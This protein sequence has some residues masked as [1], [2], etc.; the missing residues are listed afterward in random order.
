MPSVLTA[1][2]LLLLCTVFVKGILALLPERSEKS[3][4]RMDLLTEAVK[5][6]QAPA[7]SEPA[8]SQ[9]A[10]IWELIRRSEI[11]DAMQAAQEAAAAKAAAKAKSESQAATARPVVSVTLDPAIAT[12]PH[13]SP[14]QMA[15]K[16]EARFGKIV[17]VETANGTVHLR[18]QQ[19]EHGDLILPDWVTTQ[20]TPSDE[21]AG[22]YVQQTM[23]PWEI[24]E[25]LA[26]RMA[27]PQGDLF[28]QGSMQPS[29]TFH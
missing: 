27:A 22:I 18:A 5:S 10:D 12:R 11:E 15:E 8:S 21:S 7:A 3:D 19:N 25:L 1:F 23:E 4:A 2:F 16:V 28:V 24:D 13:S 20:E 26:Q 17:A 14:I 9:E 29:E 6:K